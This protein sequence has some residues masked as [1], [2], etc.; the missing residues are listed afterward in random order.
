MSDILDLDATGQI[1]ALNARRISSAELLEAAIARAEALQPKLCALGARD[2]DRARQRARLLDEQRAGGEAPGR[3]AGLPM[4]IKDVLDVEFMPASSGKRQNL[5]RPASDAAAVARVR[6]QGAVIWAKTNVAPNASDW[7]TFNDL[8]GRTNNPWDLERTPGGSSGGAAAA[9]ATRITALEL[10]SDNAGSLRV[11]ASYCGVFSLQPT[12]GMVPQRGHVPPEPGSLS[13]PD[14]NVIGPIARSTR[15]LRLLL[16]VLTSGG[17]AAE[18]RPAELK[19]LK[20]GLWLEEPGFFLDGAVKEVL[21]RFGADLGKEG[22]DVT[23]VHGPINGEALIETYVWLLYSLPGG[24]SGAWT[25]LKNEAMR[26]AAKFARRMGA[27]PQ[28][29]AGCTLGATARHEEWLQAD[30]RRAGFRR[31][32]KSWFEKR[33]VLIAPAAPVP[34]FA[35][36]TRKRS[37]RKLKTSDGRPAPYDAMIHWSALSTVCGLPAL[38]MPASSVNGLPVGVQ[39]IGAR[40]SES[41]LLSIAQAIEERLGGYLRPPL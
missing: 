19:G 13:E 15:D 38:T 6:G 20:A 18:S 31:T 17:V 16:S 35:H 25:K 33:D 32:M 3:L 37:K 11:P 30:E 28:S 34:P 26:P 5:K 24:S 36:D 29:W 22:V 4:T 27:S 7:Q 39:L 8:Y 12:Y 10:G 9:V 1:D 40:D 2:L 21:E 14:L 41:R 23:P